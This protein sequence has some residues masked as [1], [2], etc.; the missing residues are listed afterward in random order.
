MTVRVGTCG[1]QYKDWRPAFYPE[2]CSARDWLGEYARTF[3]T[4]EIDSSFYR[5]P[6]REV[7]A[8][9]A[10]AVLSGFTFA[11]KMSRYL[12][13]VLRLRDP[14]EPVRRFLDRMQPLGAKLGPILLQLGPGMRRDDSRLGAVLDMWP[15]QLRLAVE[16]RHESWFDDV[17]FDSLARAGAALVLSDRHGKPVGPVVSTTGWGYVRLHEGTATP[18]P[19]YGDKALASW[20]GRIAG[21]WGASADAYVYFNNDPNACAPRDAQR[22]M[23]LGARLGLEIQG[24]P[25]PANCEGS[26]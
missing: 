20:A 12:T 4:V 1:W 24:P 18:R 21:L 5:L 19:C 25:Q 9:W 15:R 16:F 3:P 10:S 8:R 6:S 17:V 14:D 7:T 2:T 23:R 22:F 13:H 26:R 11:A